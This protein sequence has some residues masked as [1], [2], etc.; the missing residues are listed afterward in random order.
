MET[1][2]WVYTFA[3]ISFPFLILLPQF[4]TSF[5]FLIPPI[6]LMNYFVV[7]LVYYVFL[8]V[9]SFFQLD[10]IH[11]FL[12]IDGFAYLFSVVPIGLALWYY[13]KW[14]LQ[15]QTR[16]WTRGKSA[17]KLPAKSQSKKSGKSN[18]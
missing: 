9:Y 17:K 10:M 7:L 13:G 4:A 1:N 5:K 18:K 6:H 2:A 15:G 16:Q 12:T 8:V 11:N 3:Q 14:S